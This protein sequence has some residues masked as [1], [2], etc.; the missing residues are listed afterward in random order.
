M[1]RLQQ[2]AGASV[3]RYLEGG[4]GLPVLLT[5]GSWEAAMR[6]TLTAVPEPEAT[7]GEGGTG[8]MTAAWQST[9]GSCCGVVRRALPVWAVLRSAE[10]ARPLKGSKKNQPSARSFTQGSREKKRTQRRSK[11]LAT[12]PH[13]LVSLRVK[14]EQTPGLS[15]WRPLKGGSERKD[16]EPQKNESKPSRESTFSA[17]SAAPSQ[18]TASHQTGEQP[19]PKPRLLTPIPD[20]PPRGLT[21]PQ[22][23][24][25]GNGGNLCELPQRVQH[26]GVKHL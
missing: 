17:V 2:L 5:G 1:S 9:S 22:R 24:R 13:R 19:G 16:V 21:C 25:L 18:R 20:P 11:Q 12:S 4:V 6:R 26:R 15:P 7:L 8:H 3:S 14:H 10:K 23:W